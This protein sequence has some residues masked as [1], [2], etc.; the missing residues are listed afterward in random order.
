MEEASV[1]KIKRPITVRMSD[2]H[3]HSLRHFAPHSGMVNHQE[4]TMIAT[5]SIISA[6][7]TKTLVQGIVG[8][9]RRYTEESSFLQSGLGNSHTTE[10]SDTSG[11]SVDRQHAPLGQCP[12]CTTGTVS[13]MHH[14]D[15]VQN[16]A[17]KEGRKRSAAKKE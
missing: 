2:S 6:E 8:R 1:F 7:D 4:M 15:S 10:R 14:S 16:V 12:A 13:R 5:E 3:S 11:G 9:R 17:Y